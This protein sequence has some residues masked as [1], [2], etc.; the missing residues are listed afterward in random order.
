MLYKETVSRE[1]WELLQRLMND[2]EFKDFSLVGGT[3]LSLR[4]GHRLSVDIDLFTTRDFDVNAL[5]EYLKR[6]YGAQIEE[7]SNNTIISFIGD[8]K[9][10]A[11][12]HKYPILKPVETIENVRLVSN[13]DI[14]AM[15]L[16]A[17]LQSGERLKDFVD[18]Y[19]LLDHHPLKTYLQAYERKY[20]MSVAM[21]VYSLTHYNNIR[22]EYGVSLIKGKEKSWQKMTVRLKKSVLNPHQTFEPGVSSKNKRRGI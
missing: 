8:I 13:E 4:I 18:M 10:D 9:V 7:Q 12:A 3:A 15:K 16:H 2:E 20:N 14:G 17:I 5:S 22:K 21:A 11:I 1:M 6:S 19:F